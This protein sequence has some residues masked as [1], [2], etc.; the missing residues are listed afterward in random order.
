[1]GAAVNPRDEDGMDMETA[2]QRRIKFAKDTLRTQ[3]LPHVSVEAGDE[4]K[5]AF[6]T[7]Y[8]T[9]RLIVAALGRT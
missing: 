1:M 6:F 9:Y 7:G 4:Y 3:L 8:M 5:K 2:R